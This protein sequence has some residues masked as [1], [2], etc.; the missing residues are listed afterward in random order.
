MQNI[1]MQE[2]TQEFA[3]CW[4]AAGRHLQSMAHDGK[5][6][7]L[8]ADLIPPILEHLSFRLGNQLFYVRVFDI[9]GQV[10]GPG[11][12]KGYRTIADGCKGHACLMPMRNTPRGWETCKADW[13]LIDPDSG[14]TIDPYNLVNDEKII[15]T[16]W[17]VH[18]FAVQVVRD[19]ITNKLGYEL[20]SSQGNPEVDPSIWFVGDR[21]PEWVVV[22]G[23]R[24]P[25]L[26]ATMPSNI[27]EIVDICLR[28]SR[29]G[30]FASV[31][32]ASTEDAF[33]PSGE[34]PALPLWRGHGIFVRFQGLG[35]VEIQ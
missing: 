10:K 5:L 16:D 4:Q 20:M 17:E 34:I 19:Q 3:R 30:Y 29:T 14:K 9:D 18:D 8:K 33:D 21:G 26:E 13:G 12:D 24:Y 31:G 11:N 27:A 2:A 23:V 32:C 7:W 35:P 1:E 28:T 6:N 15:M 25:D 22:R